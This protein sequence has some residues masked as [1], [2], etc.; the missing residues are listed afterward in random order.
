ML[1][2]K[3]RRATMIGASEIS[4]TALSVRI[5]QVAARQ[6]APVRLTSQSRTASPS[7]DD[8][9]VRLKLPIMLW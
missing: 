9:N 5:E 6:P 8:G 4:P 1:Q 7:I 2:L 3:G